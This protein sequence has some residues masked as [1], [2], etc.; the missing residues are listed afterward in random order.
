MHCN[1]HSPLFTCTVKTIISVWTNIYPTLRCLILNRNLIIIVWMTGSKEKLVGQRTSWLYYACIAIF[2]HHCL[3]LCC[4][5]LNRCL[6]FTMVYLFTIVGWSWLPDN[7][8][9][10]QRT[11]STYNKCVMTGSKEKISWYSPLRIPVQTE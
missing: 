1:I 7:K 9:I 11:S 2:I 6:I 4:L 5:I 8:F 10:G 3:T